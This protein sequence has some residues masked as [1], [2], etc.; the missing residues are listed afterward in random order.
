MLRFR[1][2]IIE[3]WFSGAKFSEDVCVD[4]QCVTH[5]NIGS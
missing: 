5:I 1:Q 4:K 3:K 2:Y